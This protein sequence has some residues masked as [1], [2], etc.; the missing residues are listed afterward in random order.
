MTATQSYTAMPLFGVLMASDLTDRAA[1]RLLA[2]QIITQ[3][4]LE[5]GLTQDQVV[6]HTTIPSTSQLSDYENGKLGIGRSKHFASVARYLRLPRESIMRINPLYSLD[7]VPIPTESGSIRNDVV[8]LSHTMKNVFDLAQASRPLEEMEPLPE[9]SPV[10]VANRDLRSGTELFLVRGES[11]TISGERGILDGDMIYVDT[12]DTTPQLERVYVIHIPGS[13]VCLKRVRLIG[14]EMY[15]FSDNEDQGA[16]PPFRTDEA[17][18]I[19]RVH[20][21]TRTPRVR[22]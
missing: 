20:H 17:R 14:G 21:V 15:L 11:M 10:L 8:A 18:V 16:Y 9:I 1:E 12:H 6:E 3:R 2:G 13:G 19:G 22:L 5:L 4:R 7:S